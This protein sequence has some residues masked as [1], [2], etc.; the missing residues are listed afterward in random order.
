M[1]V[2]FWINESLFQFIFSC[3]P[4]SNQ[5]QTDSDRVGHLYPLLRQTEVWSIF[6]LLGFQELPFLFARNRNPPTI[7]YSAYHD[8]AHK[9][10]SLDPRLR[11]YFMIGLKLI[12]SQM[13]IFFTAKNILTVIVYGY[14]NIWNPFVYFP[15]KILSP[16]IFEKTIGFQTE[17]TK[18]FMEQK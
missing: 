8:S 6:I 16:I 3:A 4:Y 5:I 1:R 10:W 17:K 11:L 7:T 13:M 12:Q 15:L 9:P 2:Y 18:I 14:R